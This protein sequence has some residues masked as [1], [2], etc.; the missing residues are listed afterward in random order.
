MGQ[1][2]YH[3]AKPHYFRSGDPGFWSDSAVV[4]AQASVNAKATLNG[5]AKQAQH[6]KR[7]EAVQD[8]TTIQGGSDLYYVYT[9]AKKGS[10]GL[11][12]DEHGARLATQLG[13]FH[14][15][16]I[17]VDGSKVDKTTQ[18]TLKKEY[19][20][21]F[22]RESG[23]KAV[24]LMTQDMGKEVQFG[25]LLRARLN[26]VALAA[27]RKMPMSK[28]LQ[29]ALREPSSEPS[30]PPRAA[31]AFAIRP[32]PDVVEMEDGMCSPLT[33]IDPAHVSIPHTRVDPA[34]SHRSRALAPIPRARA[35]PARSHRSRALA[36]IPRARA[37]PARS[38]RSR[39]LASIPPPRVDP[40]HS[41]R[42]RPLASTL[43]PL[44]IL[45]MQIVRQI[46]NA[47]LDNWAN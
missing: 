7:Q 22:Q 33:R 37:D 26:P 27:I 40:A 28:T 21:L 25:L 9:A 24:T 17:N 23:V 31:P 14:G 47:L 38:H 35:D 5:P 36:P 41:R 6:V 1:N 46:S 16:A 30:S 43:C 42:S 12:F 34:R 8:L 11:C 29:D 39:V 20:K 19:D 13:S 10:T 44:M 3:R 2:P 18:E 15:L 45:Q 32:V 4:I